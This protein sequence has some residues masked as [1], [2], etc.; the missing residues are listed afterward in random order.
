MHAAAGSADGAQRS[1]AVFDPGTMNSVLCPGGVV[2]MI[3]EE[4]RGVRER[5]RNVVNTS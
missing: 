4:K 5:A 3:I 1:G 2:D